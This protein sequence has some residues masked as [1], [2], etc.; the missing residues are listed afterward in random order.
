[1]ADAEKNNMKEYICKSRSLPRQLKEISKPIFQVLKDDINSPVNVIIENKLSTISE[2]QN[3]YTKCLN[4]DVF[5]AFYE[6]YIDFK[7]YINDILKSNFTLTNS[8]SADD[9]L[10]K[11]QPQQEEDKNIEKTIKE[12]NKKIQMLQEENNNLKQENNTF[13]EMLELMP[14]QNIQRKDFENLKIV[15]QKFPETCS[16]SDQTK[17]NEINN[18]PPLS[19]RFQ[20]LGKP[21]IDFSIDRNL[22]EKINDFKYTQQV[23][24]EKIFNL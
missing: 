14:E 23:I 5:E 7:S 13:L 6:D 15:K 24:I 16:K 4:R 10:Q 22:T 12:L 11:Q 9:H 21:E 17:N 3:H 1:M 20:N 2:E 8:I 18:T 19:N